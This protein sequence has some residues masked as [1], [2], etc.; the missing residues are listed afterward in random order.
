MQ[1]RSNL[2]LYGDNMKYLPH[3]PSGAFRLI[4]ID[5]P[6]NTGKV[7]Q[8]IRIR[9]TASENGTRIGFGNRKYAVQTCP[10]P[11][12]AD[13]FDDYLAFLRPRLIEARRLLTPDGSLFVHL[14]YREVHYVKVML[15]EIFGR[16]CFMKAL[17]CACAGSPD[18]SLNRRL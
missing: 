3:L 5:P 18:C 9:A 6:F 8:R 13:D 2:I 15:D 11:A 14:D 7:Q 1:L 10:S 12:Y 4:Y 17:I 16:D